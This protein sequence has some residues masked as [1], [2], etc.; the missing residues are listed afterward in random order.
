LSPDIHQEIVVSREKVG[1]FKQWFE[2][3]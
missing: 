3:N 2:G 1:A